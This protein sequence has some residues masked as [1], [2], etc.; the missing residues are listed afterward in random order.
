MTTSLF[1]PIGTLLFASA[2][3]ALYRSID[4]GNS[5]TLVAKNFSGPLIWTMTAM[6]QSIFIGGYGIGMY[7][8]D[9]LGVHWQKTVS[10]LTDQNIFALASDG[11]VL[12]AGTYSNWIARSL[13]GG[14]TWTESPGNESY[15]LPDILSSNSTQ[16]F[17]GSNFGIHRFDASEKKWI[18]RGNAIS[19][20]A[21]VSAIVAT[22]NVI[23]CAVGQDSL[24]YRSTSNGD[25]WELISGWPRC[26]IDRLTT[27]DGIIYGG[28]SETGS[29]IIR[30]SDLGVTWG[31]C[32]ITSGGSGPIPT[33]VFYSIKKFGKYLIASGA[34]NSVPVARSEDNG[35]SWYLI[36][37]SELSQNSISILA[38]STI[39]PTLIAACDYGGR[40]YQSIDTGSSWNKVYEFGNAIYGMVEYG[41]DLFIA[42]ETG[43]FSS[44]DLGATWSSKNDGLHDTAILALALLKDN[45]Y[46]STES[47]V[48]RRPRSELSVKNSDQCTVL[49]NDFTAF[50]NPFT[51]ET[52]LTINC[53]ESMSMQFEIYDI[54]GKKIYDGGEKLYSKGE[55]AITL[56]TSNFSDGFLY[57]RFTSSIG[58]TRSITLFKSQ[59]QR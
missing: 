5:W 12:L 30:S 55:N 59:S 53:P 25:S 49:V 41:N 13:D 34:Y 54:L 50:P 47:G 1:N 32:T 33:P 24:L 26:R 17:S 31:T 46:I 11:M 58:D 8:S 21:N 28:G 6:D 35:L 18:P 40:I 56:N 37:P 39:G 52:S 14:V 27:I 7:R 4:E 19:D 43:I 42:T 15:A 16:L 22:D 23:V 10:T 3:S 51:T 48:Y 57:G 2:D 20:I 9:D 44:S 36:Q 45:L 38:L 29:P